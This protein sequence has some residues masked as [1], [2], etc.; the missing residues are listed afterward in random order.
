VLGVLFSSLS[1]TILLALSSLVFSGRGQA[2]ATA[3]L[4]ETMAGL[5]RVLNGEFWTERKE[6]EPSTD[7]A[8]E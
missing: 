2:R 3:I 5:A 6:E 4:L 7:V 1:I 8:S